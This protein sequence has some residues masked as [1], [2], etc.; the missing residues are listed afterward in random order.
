VRLDRPP[1]SAGVDCVVAVSPEPRGPVAT[2]VSVVEVCPT[3]VGVG[4]AAVIVVT[5]GAVDGTVVV[6]PTVVVV[7]VVVD[8]GAGEVV[9][10]GATVVVVVV[11]V[12][13][14]PFPGGGPAAWN[15]V[16]CTLQPCGPAGGAGF[17]AGS[18][19]PGPAGG[20]PGIGFESSGVIASRAVEVVPL[21]P[22]RDAASPEI[23]PTT[24]S[25]PSPA[26]TMR[27]RFRCRRRFPP[28]DT[29]NS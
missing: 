20:S 16:R 26:T 7:I 17:G 25:A 22:E 10:G 8:V 18:G 28:T 27:R 12:V 15:A 6:G 29:A 3:V 19:R 14:F 13:F 23:E 11:V 4:A 2:G 1:A 5:V 24:I 9:V 21:P